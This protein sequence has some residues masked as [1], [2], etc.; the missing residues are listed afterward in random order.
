MSTVTYQHTSE[1]CCAGG[2][3]GGH[4]GRAMGGLGSGVKGLQML[5]AC[6]GGSGC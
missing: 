4:S 2:D 1:E 3:V 6:F 5:K